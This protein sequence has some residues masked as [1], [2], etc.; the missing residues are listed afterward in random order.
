MSATETKNFFIRLPPAAFSRAPFFVD[1]GFR[2][3]GVTFCVA[4]AAGCA[5]TGFS[6]ARHASAIDGIHLF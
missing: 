3:A 2:R 6:A 4:V 1:Y 5:V